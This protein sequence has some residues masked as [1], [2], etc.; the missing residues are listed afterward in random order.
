MKRALLLILSIGMLYSC[1]NT[2]S[3]QTYGGVKFEGIY[4]ETEAGLVEAHKYKLEVPAGGGEYD[5]EMAAVR[6]FDEGTLE[7]SYGFVDVIQTVVSI[8]PDADNYYRGT[9]H[10]TVPKNNTDQNRSVDVRLYSR[11]GMRCAIMTI[12]QEKGF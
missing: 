6:P 9:L 8:A 3:E 10:L 1:T 4:F 7:L 2:K 11:T 5:F 12:S